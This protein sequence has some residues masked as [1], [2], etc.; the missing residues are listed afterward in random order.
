M[1]PAAFA[2]ILAMTVLDA[3]ALDVPAAPDDPYLWLEDVTAEKSLDWARARNAES[4]KAL[5]TGGFPSLERRI[6][7][8]LDSRARIPDVTKMG[9]HYYNFWQDAKNPRG[10]WRRT[11]LDEYRKSEPLWERVLDLDAL[12][13][14]EEENWVWQRATCLRPAY[15]RC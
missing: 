1:R 12:G 8:I 9:R 11:T 15:R 7:D 13:A 3:R 10:L 6:L 5:E 14:A 2:F 4:A